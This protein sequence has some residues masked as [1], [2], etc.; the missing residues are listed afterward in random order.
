VP[1]AACASEAL[2]PERSAREAEIASV[3]ATGTNVF[4]KLGSDWVIEGT[5]SVAGHTVTVT[6]K[7]GETVE[8]VVRNVTEVAGGRRQVATFGF[9][10]DPPRER[11]ANRYRLR[12][13]TDRCDECGGR[14]S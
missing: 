11:E 14:T 5:N 10:P 6:K 3:V 1:P 9:V 8:R 7:G 4:R 12:Q 2:G 13:A